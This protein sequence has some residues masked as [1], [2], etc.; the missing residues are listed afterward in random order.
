VNCEITYEE[1]SA[2]AAGELEGERENEIHRH[3]G[4]C[5]RCRTRLA[6]LKK[7]DEALRRVGVYR[8][9]AGVLLGVRRAL[10]QEV[11]GPE[12][13]EIM[14]LDEVGEFLRLSPGQ[15]GEI[16]EE[17]PAFELAG[18]VRIRRT[19]LVEWLQQREQAYARQTAASWVA[20]SAVKFGTGAA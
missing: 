16:A 15:L 5:E 4:E 13:R 7:T 3:L 10:A 20:R 1:L 18:Q 17:L 12:A 6:A 19:R 2:F 8:P 11:R 9:P 14:T